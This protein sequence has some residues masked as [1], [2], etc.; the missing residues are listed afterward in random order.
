MHIRILL[1]IAALACCPCLFGQGA[2]PGTGP[3]TST[4]NAGAVRSAATPKLAAPIDIAGYWTAVVTEDWM[5]RM[6]TPPKGQFLGVP[7]NPAGRAAANAWDPA[8]DEAAGDSCKAYGAGGVMRQPGRLHI[9]W[10]DDTTLKLE[11]EAGNQTR[12]L[13]FSDFAAASQPTLQGDSKA[14]WQQA[15]VRRGE[16]RAGNLKVVTNNLKA[17]Y[18]RKNGVPYGGNAIVN[19]FYDSYPGPDGDQWLVVTTEVVDPQYLTQTFV[20]SSHFRKLPDD[21]GAKMWKPEACSAK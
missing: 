10:Q 21:L 8:R 19:E 3:T 16:A 5:F 12:V 11:L 20:T 14:Q 13:H 6:V 17:G 18:L 7:L 9:T 4:L 2:G 1:A 15:A